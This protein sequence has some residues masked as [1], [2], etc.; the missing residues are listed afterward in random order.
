MLTFYHKE[1]K[2]E[3]V[4]GHFFITDEDYEENKCGGY[5]SSME[6]GT[7]DERMNDNFE[8]KNSFY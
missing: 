3:M 5:Q 2:Y 8:V 1:T 7:I 4:H 6:N